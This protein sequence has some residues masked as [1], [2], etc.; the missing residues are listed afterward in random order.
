MKHTLANVYYLLKIIFQCSENDKIS[1][2]D[3]LDGFRGILAFSVILQHTTGYFK[4]AIEYRV[5]AGLGNNFGVPSFFVLSSF[6]LTYRQLELM[7]NSNGSFNAILIIIIKYL[8]RRFFRIYIPFF[9]YATFIKLEFS[10]N[11]FGLRY[12]SYFD[13]ITL[14][15]MGYNHL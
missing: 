8:I 6:L 14:K 4:M 10:T 7:S 3:V 12:P 5:C 11:L 1:R 15:V 2:F 13:L 9:V